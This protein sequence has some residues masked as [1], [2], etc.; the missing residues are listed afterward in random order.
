MKHGIDKRICIVLAAMVAVMANMYAKTDTIRKGLSTKSQVE[1]LERIADT[2][3]HSAY[4]DSIRL[5]GYNKTL[6]DRDE[7]FYVTNR[8]PFDISRLI[9]RFTYSDANGEM[10]HEEEYDIDCQIPAGT[11]RQLSVR[12]WDK[13]HTH[14]YYKSRKPR[15]SAVP[16]RIKY[17]LL[18][19]DV[20][21]TVNR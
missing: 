11:T 16:Y 12:S 15:R 9:V 1:Q 2:N 19:Y 14:Y 17:T 13:Q 5:S 6:T 20:A 21:I 18:R 8:T 4:A 3:G 7:T 10:L